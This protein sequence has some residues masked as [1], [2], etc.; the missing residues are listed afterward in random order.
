MKVLLTG[1][2][3]L[4][5]PFMSPK[6]QP[7]DSVIANTSP[8]PFSALDSRNSTLKETPIRMFGIK[9]GL[10]WAE[11]YR[12]GFGYYNLNT[13]FKENINYKSVQNSFKGR[14]HFWYISAFGEK[15]FFDNQKFHLNGTFHLGMGQS[16]FKPNNKPAL[17]D[18]IKKEFVLLVEPHV[19]GAYKIIPWLGVGAG[20]GYRKSIIPDLLRTDNFNGGV[21]AISV[22][23][24]PFAL[25]EAIFNKEKGLLKSR[26]NPLTNFYF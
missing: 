10:Q 17:P 6:A 21:V 2:F 16:F 11:K 14:F 23:V 3:L 18:R 5:L 20:L 25:Y 1:L 4:L 12:L 8:V 9:L 7:L 13:H 24:F 22:Q 15:Q 19:S 26:A